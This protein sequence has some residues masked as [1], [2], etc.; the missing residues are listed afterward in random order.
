MSH[1]RP[2][3]LAAV[4]QAGRK[5]APKP[6][7]KAAVAQAPP[8]PRRPST[9]SKPPTPAEVAQLA[10]LVR[11]ALIHACDELL[12]RGPL[13]Q[14]MCQ[15]DAPCAKAARL[16]AA[17]RD[18]PTERAGWAVLQRYMLVE[19]YQALMAGLFP[20]EFGGAAVGACPAAGP[21]R[22]GG[23]R[24]REFVRLMGPVVPGA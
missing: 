12:L 18:A 15:T 4:T 5:P 16:L 13:G 21:R 10:A 22:V 19:V 23:P 17:L 2:S 11:G 14:A 7:T 6:A 9:P 20:E 24:L 3:K 1:Q 8:P